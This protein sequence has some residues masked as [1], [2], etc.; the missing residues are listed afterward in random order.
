MHHRRTVG[1]AIPCQVASP[2]SLTPFRR[3]GSSL[4]RIEFR[5]VGYGAPP[6][7]AKGHWRGIHIGRAWT[8]I[9]DPGASWRKFFRADHPGT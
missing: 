3:A 1:L 7:P 4:T 5:G 2:Q 8:A 6:Q 9:V